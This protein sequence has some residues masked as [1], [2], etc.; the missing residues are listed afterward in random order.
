MRE[1]LKNENT[2]KRKILILE[3]KIKNQKIKINLLNRKINYLQSPIR[4]LELTEIIQ[5][6][7]N[8]LLN[9]PLRKIRASDDGIS[10][11]YK[12][13]ATNVICVINAGKSDDSK[14]KIYLLKPRKDIKNKIK[15]TNIV[16]IHKGRSLDYLCNEIDSTKFHIARISQT[17]AVNVAFYELINNY[18]YLKVKENKVKSIQKLR[19][20]DDYLADFEAKKE[21]Y[22]TVRIFHKTHIFSKFNM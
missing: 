8:I 11:V 18:A 17:A 3:K 6:E 4:L 2:L 19:V 13:K 16:S 20:S 14:K 10:E 15:V 21:A 7:Y 5:D 12:L 22:E 9:P 1:V